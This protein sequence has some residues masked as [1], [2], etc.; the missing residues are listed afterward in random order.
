MILSKYEKLIMALL[1]LLIVISVIPSKAYAEERQYLGEVVNTG[2]DNGYS[3]QN[4]FETDDPHYGWKLGSF[5]ISGYTRV[6]QDENDNPVFLKNVGDKVTL[7]FLLEQDIDNLNGISNLLIAEDTN[8]YDKYFELEKTNFGRGAL[9]IKYTDYQNLNNEPTIYTD[10]LSGLTTNANTTVEL[11]EEG[12]YEVAL[13]YE[14]KS[15][16]FLFFHSYEN[17]RIYFKFSVRNG[18]SMVYPFDVLTKGELTNSSLTENG[19]YLDLAK[20]RYLDID[21]KK[22]VLVQGS[23]ALT[24][25]TRFNRPAKDGEQ[26]TDEGIYT[27]T[28]RNLYTGLE[29][30]KKIYVGTNNILKAHVKTGL[31]INEINAQL[32]L[33]AQITNEGDIISASQQPAETNTHT[34][35]GLSVNSPEL[36]TDEIERSDENSPNTDQKKYNRYLVAIVGAAL[37]LV[38]LLV[39]RKYRRSKTSRSDNYKNDSKEEG[40]DK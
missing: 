10:Y 22:E 37:L 30:T 27:I 14:I 9:I 39:I 38:I 31:P 23:D 12:D 16:N 19:F 11:F 6:T 2:K 25:D 34:S 36:T 7:S 28:V 5:S 24:E 32:E 33:G 18:N 4:S 35:E 17:Y 13:N 15:D 40:T 20:S 8:G 1:T 21:V 29:T 3:E 26:Y